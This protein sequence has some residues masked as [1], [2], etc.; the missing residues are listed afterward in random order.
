MSKIYTKVT[1]Y[2]NESEHT[3]HFIRL[4]ADSGRGG[5]SDVTIPASVIFSLPL[6]SS[7]LFF[8]FHFCCFFMSPL[9]PISC[10]Q[11]WFVFHIN[12]SERKR[13]TERERV[14]FFFLEIGLVPVVMS[15][16]QEVRHRLSVVMSTKYDQH[17]YIGKDGQING[18]DEGCRRG[19]GML[20]FKYSCVFWWTHASACSLCSA[21]VWNVIAGL[22]RAACVCYALW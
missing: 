7:P 6:H 10:S 4:R 18:E 16:E 8:L 5:S 15:S 11:L 9:H 1:R 17:A 3:L 21:L 2:G 20:N 13:E 19:L 22:L 12:M 14:I